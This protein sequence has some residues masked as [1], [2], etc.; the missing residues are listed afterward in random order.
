MGWT[1]KRECKECLV[2][3][4]YISSAASPGFLLPGKFEFALAHA[5]NL[6]EV[7]RTVEEK[8]IGAILSGLHSVHSD[9]YTL[10]LSPTR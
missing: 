1:L 5:L 4:L 9:P 7:G 10:C 8:R 6:V 2:I 3:L